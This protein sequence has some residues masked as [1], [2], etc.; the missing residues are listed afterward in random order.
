MAV[1]QKLNVFSCSRQNCWCSG[2][3]HHEFETFE[4]MKNFWNILMNRRPEWT[5]KLFTDCLIDVQTW[6]SENYIIQLYLFLCDMK[7]IKMKEALWEWDGFIYSWGVSCR[8][9]IMWMDTTLL[10]PT[11]VDVRRPE[12]KTRQSAAFPRK[13]D[14]TFE[15]EY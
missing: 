15:Y 11:D 2:G 7:W 8:W 4:I 6:R 3:K 1:N 10:L 13:N 14:P 9:D 5:N 12:N